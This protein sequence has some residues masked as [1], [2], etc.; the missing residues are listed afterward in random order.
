MERFQHPITD[1]HSR[2]SRNIMIR[3]A[4]LARSGAAPGMTAEDIAQDLREHLWRRDGAFDLTRGSYDTFADR[5]IAN[6]IATLA[7][8]TERLKA[9]RSWVSFDEPTQKKEDGAPLPLS[10]TLAEADGLNGPAPRSA[11]EGFG[12]VRDVRRL[13]AALTPACRSMAD[14]LVDLTPSEA[15][16]ALGIHRSTVYARLASMRSAAVA[17]GLEVYLGATPTVPAPGR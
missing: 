5:V 16:I 15:A 11:D 13:R 2:V 1:P 12:L 8:P 7:S 14:A 6:R 4:R 3:A 9:E 10:E 17:R